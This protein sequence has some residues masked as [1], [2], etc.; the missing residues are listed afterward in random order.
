MTTTLPSILVELNISVWTA[1]KVD[2]RVTDKATEDAQAS[3]D[4]GQF[5]KNLMAGTLT[6]KKIADYAA[7]CRLRHN[8]ATLPWQ[9]KGGRLL[10]MSMFLDYKTQMDGC[11]A[12]FDS[13]VDK[14]VAEYPQLVQAAQAS[15]GDMFDPLDYPPADRVREKF[16]FRLVFSPIPEAGDFRISQFNEDKQFL[17]A[18]Y[19]AE[20]NNRVNDAMTAAWTRLHTMLKTM[21]EKLAEPEEGKKVFHDSFTTNALE[22]CDLLEHLNI[23]EDPKMKEAQRGLR[24]AIRNVDIDD[25]RKDAGT[26]ITLKED[27]D[28]VLKKFDW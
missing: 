14:F 18:Q 25:I 23:T 11:K 16:G 26:R 27:V 21:S 3:S 9:D 24:N 7:R 10:P 8:E 12:Y 2:R 17:I 20:I 5:K 6:R 22:L 1:N 19:E 4:A 15:L 28:A 13:E